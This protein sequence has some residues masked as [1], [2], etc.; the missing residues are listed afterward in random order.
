MPHCTTSASRSNGSLIPSARIGNGLTIIAQF[1]RVQKYIHLFGGDKSR[2]T[3]AGQSAGGGSVEHHLASYGGQGSVPFAQ[4]LPASPAFH[5]VPNMTEYLPAHQK[6]FAALNVTTLEEARRLPSEQ[7]ILANIAIVWESTYG[8]NSFGPVVDGTYV[9][10]LPG[11]A[12]LNGSFHK[13]V[14]VFTTHNTNEGFL[15]SNPQINTSIAFTAYV[16]GQF[17]FITNETVEYITQ[18]LYPPIYDGSY[19]YTN[20]FERQVALVQ[21]SSFIC[22]SNYIDRAYDN[23]TFSCK[24][25]SKNDKISYF[26]ILMV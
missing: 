3:L 23:N 26:S 17:P 10:T 8:S 18:V 6:F 12:F 9:P 20:D 11:L 25:L 1:F 13:D 21:D 15:F 4:A 16:K 2:V 7:L 24:I 14:N 22:N 5:P 19:G